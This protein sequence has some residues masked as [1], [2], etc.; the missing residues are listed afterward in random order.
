MVKARVQLYLFDHGEQQY[1]VVRDLSGLWS[2]GDGDENYLHRRFQKGLTVDA[3][4]QWAM[5]EDLWELP[6]NEASAAWWADHLFTL[7]EISAL[8]D[9]EF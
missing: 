4:M 2:V 7:E 3:H 9:V 5:N 1:R 8:F 6:R